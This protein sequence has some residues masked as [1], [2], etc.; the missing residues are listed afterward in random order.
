MQLA[1]AGL[2]TT[3]LM[4]TWS[5]AP[6][7]AG[8]PPAQYTDRAAARHRGA[9]EAVARLSPAVD[10]LRHRTDMS[11]QAADTPVSDI[12]AAREADTPAA[13]ILAG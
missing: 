11:A 9:A 6:R 13:G 10:N 8:K 12:L 2:A 3:T 1:Q 7:I 4:G 5:A